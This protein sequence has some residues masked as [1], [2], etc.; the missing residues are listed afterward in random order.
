MASTYAEHYQICR[1]LY[2]E[3]K[4]DSIY[5]SAYDVSLDPDWKKPIADF[6]VKV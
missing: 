1:K 3:K 4:D 2:R 5:S 6:L